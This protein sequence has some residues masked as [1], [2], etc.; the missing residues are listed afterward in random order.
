M[1]RE[2]FLTTKLFEM[3]RL[4]WEFRDSLLLLIKFIIKCNTIFP[5][6]WNHIQKIRFPWSIRTYENISNSIFVIM[7]FNS[8]NCSK[9]FYIRERKNI[10]Y[11]NSWE[12][13]DYFW[14]VIK[15]YRI[16][17]S[18]NSVCISVLYIRI[19]KYN[20]NISFIVFFD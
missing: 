7:K 15:L 2:M 13:H 12:L 9:I 8:F 5:Y 11:F 19:G 18:V 6:W 4:W 14:W 17:D 16:N 3:M 20:I 1:R 10:G